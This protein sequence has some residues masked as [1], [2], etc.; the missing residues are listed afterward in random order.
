M[1][2]FGN[3]VVVHAPPPF[4]NSKIAENRKQD[5]ERD[6]LA[7]VDGQAVVDGYAYERIGPYIRTCLDH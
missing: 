2:W 3:S 1:P 4:L 5:V 7:S 6:L